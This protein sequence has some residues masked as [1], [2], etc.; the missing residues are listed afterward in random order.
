MSPL[1]EASPTEIIGVTRQHLEETLIA[2]R[3]AWNYQSATD[4]MEAARDGK[5]TSIKS[6]LT[7]K[8]ERSYN[9]LEGYLVEDVIPE[10]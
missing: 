10:G 8:L 6:S 9:H 7:R 4:V 1:S 2:L 5:S 3:D